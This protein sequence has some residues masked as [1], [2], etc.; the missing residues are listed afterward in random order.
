MARLG[1]TR[2]EGCLVVIDTSGVARIFTKNAG[3]VYATREGQEG[4]TILDRCFVDHDASY[5]W[6]PGVK[7]PK[8]MMNIN[9]VALTLKRAIAKDIHLSATAK[10]S[11]DSV[12]QTLVPKHKK[13]ASYYLVAEADTKNKLPINKGTIIMGRDN[14][15]DIV[16]SNPDI[17]RRHCLLQTIPRGVRFRDLESSNGVF[18]NGIH[19][20][21]GFVQPGD[22][23]SLGSYALTICRES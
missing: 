18:I 10:V 12:A 21:E 16:L 8:E 2:D 6:M 15:C 3:V 9:I 7:P 5:V 1:Q 17:S 13:V 23:L 22:K 20:K 19:A 4:E 14:S 11:L